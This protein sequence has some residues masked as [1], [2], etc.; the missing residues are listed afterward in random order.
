MNTQ[1][2]P[3][4]SLH[5]LYPIVGWRLPVELCASDADDDLSRSVYLAEGHS[6]DMA[7]TINWAISVGIIDNL[8]NCSTE[9]CSV[10]SSD[11]VY[12]VPAFSGLQAPYDDTRAG[13]MFIG[14]H[15]HTSR[16]HLLRAVLDACAF[17]V[18]QVY[19]TMVQES[20]VQPKVIR[21]C[22]GV[23]R[24]D[25][26]LTQLSTLCNVR[27]QRVAECEYAAARGVAF[28]AGR[29]AKIWDPEVDIDKF[30]RI[31]AEFMPLSSAEREQIL[32]NYTEWQ[33]AVQRS[34]KWHAEK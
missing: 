13:T 14:M 22:G 19:S 10:P 1:Q 8:S 2:R 21:C 28:M 26:I 7:T 3:H 23:S 24:N 15:N 31:E 5:G 29:I 30:Q 20:R 32:S 11:G 27:V 12:F 17:R 25:F 9:A 4:T 33:R 18:Y 16:I 34:L 6:H